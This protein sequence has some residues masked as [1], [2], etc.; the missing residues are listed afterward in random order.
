MATNIIE[1]LQH[2]LNS[3][4]LQ[5]V[6]PNT[7]E[8]DKSATDTSNASKLQQ[9]VISAVLTGVYKIT[10][11]HEG[12]E[13]ILSG[14]ISTSWGDFLFADS[15]AALISHIVK[16]SVSSP[17][18][19]QSEIEIAGNE[20][21]DIIR[22]NAGGNKISTADDVITYMKDQRNKILHY[23]PAAL[24]LGALLDD[25]TLDDHTHKMDGPVSGLMHKIEKAFSGTPPA[26]EAK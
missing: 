7:Q 3:K 26:D 1:L 6:N 14:N 4:P 18:A 15:K 24:Q 19:V 8:V 17:A 20:T 23:L 22:T 9:A 25:D 2:A 16:Y 10:R 5:K 11:T 21:S 12:A 13:K